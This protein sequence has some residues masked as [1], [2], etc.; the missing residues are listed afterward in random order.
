M[1]L[2]RRSP[3]EKLTDDLKG[4]IESMSE[5]ICA[6]HCEDYVSYARCVARLEALKICRDQVSRILAEDFDE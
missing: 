6:G 3:A 1:P 5:Y 4:Q 2:A